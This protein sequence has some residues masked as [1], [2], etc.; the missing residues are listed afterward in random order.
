MKRTKLIASLMVCV[1][2]LSFLVVGVFA[3]ISSANLNVN[4]NIKY[5]PEG[6]FVEL[7]GQVYRGSSTED[8]QPITSDPRFSYGPVA[9]FDA[10]LDQPSGNF[11]LETWNIGNIS[12]IPTQKFI[13]IS[14]TIT[15]YSDFAIM[16]TPNIT[17]DNTDITS[18]QNFKVTTTD[19]INNIVSLQTATYDIII[20]VLAAQEVTGALNVS[21]EFE[22]YV[23]ITLNGKVYTG[24]THAVLAPI[25]TNGF[26]GGASIDSSSTWDNLQATLTNTNKAVKY[27]MEVTNASETG[28]KGVGDF[29][30]AGQSKPTPSLVAGGVN[31]YE[32]TDYT[33]TEYAQYIQNIQPTDTQI[34]E[35]VIEL[36]ENV[37]S[38]TINASIDF[39]FTDDKMYS[40]VFEGQTYN[41]VN[42]GKYPQR[43]VGN[44]MN[45]VLEAWYTEQNPTSVTSYTTF[46]GYTY[47]GGIYTQNE[48]V[49]CNAYNYIDSNTYVRVGEPEFHQNSY[50]YMN[51]EI[52][53]DGQV[54]WFKVEPIQWRV[55]IEN[56]NSTGSAMLLS[57][58]ALSANTTYYYDIA[59]A[60]NQSTSGYAGYKSSTI[61]EF[62]INEKVIDEDGNKISEGFFYEALT[63]QEQ[64]KVI[65]RT[66]SDNELDPSNVI[67]ANTS[68]SDMVWLPTY[69]DYSSSSSRTSPTDFALANYANLNMEGSSYPAPARQDGASTNYWTSSASGPSDYAQYVDYHNSVTRD[70]VGQRSI[71]VRPALLFKLDV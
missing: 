57:E 67:T 17:I 35:L 48:P 46:K 9:N 50:T 31:I 71:T 15:N 23:P 64:K 41:Y 11:P 58:L 53:T 34:Y 49:I 44:E 10:T 16:G 52:V 2:C 55:L 12:F 56:Y 42:M 33:V 6:L 27:R 43:Y 19:N 22:E 69:K 38:A 65:K 13:K 54:A 37:A 3:A 59:A 30:I 25:S 5:Y 21:F 4:G 32:Y 70:E 66:L 1:F 14:V 68:V 63:V 8:M 18:N 47:N 26:T 39:D 45:D 24:E 51:G 28:I 36:N 62:L 7:S 40:T 20:E 61:R 60:Q 29:A